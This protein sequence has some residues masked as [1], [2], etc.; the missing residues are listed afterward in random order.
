MKAK[1]ALRAPPSSLV[2]SSSTRTVQTAQSVNRR[3]FL[4]EPICRHC[5]RQTTSVGEENGRRAGDV[6]RLAELQVLVD[7]GRV[8]ASGGGGR[9]VVEHP[10]FP[11]ART[12]LRTPD[13]LRLDRRIRRQDRVQEGVDGDV[14]DGLA[15]FP[16]ACSTGNSDRR[17][18]RSCARPYPS[19]P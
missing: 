10:A 12:I 9:R 2:D 17:T 18:P 5:A 15:W 3:Q 4:L 8:A 7:G 1:E 13:R 14:I 11:C 16:T 19:P 6:H